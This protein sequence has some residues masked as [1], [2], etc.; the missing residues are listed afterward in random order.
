MEAWGWSG[1]LAV[2]LAAL[3]ARAAGP[4]PDEA[5]EVAI[6]EL[7]DELTQKTPIASGHAEPVQETPGVVTIV[8]REEILSSGARDLLDVLQLVPGFSAVGVDVEG[9]TDFGFR[10]IWAH[11][12]KILLMI[13][14]LPRNEL[15][16]DDNELG[17]HYPVDQIERVEIIRGAGSVLYGGWAEL[18]VIN[19]ITRSAK[20]LSGA[21]GSF[22]YGQMTRGFGQADLNLQAGKADLLGVKGLDLKA[23]LYWG[24][25]NRSD[26]S[27]LDFYGNSYSMLGASSLDPFNIDAALDWKSL[28]V[29]FLY[30]HYQLAEADSYTEVSGCGATG[31]NGSPLPCPYLVGEQFNTTLGDV[32]YDFKLGD[33][34]TLTPRFT[35]KLQ[36]PWY[37][38][39]P[40]AGPQYF[41][42]HAE[43]ATGRLDLSWDLFRDA[44]PWLGSLHL[45]AGTEDYYEDAAL[46]ERPPAGAVANYFGAPQ[47]PGATQCTL[48]DGTP[49][50]CTSMNEYNLAGYAELQWKSL[51]GALTAGARYEHNSEFGDS[52][53]PRGAYTKAFGR[54][55][56]K[57]L[58]SSAFRAPGLEDVNL[59][60][61]GSPIRPE[62]TQDGE[63]ELG[64]QA[65][66]HWYVGANAFY[67]VIKD[68]IVYY[69]TQ[70][71][72]AE[73]YLNFPQTG[74]EG[75][76]A[77]V[78]MKY[79]WGNLK[80]NYSYYTSWSIFTDQSMNQVPLYA[81]P[82]DPSL[83]AGFPA[84]KVSLNGHFVIWKGL[85][86]NPSGNFLSRRYGQWS[87]DGA[88]NG[89][90]SLG[91]ATWLLNL[92][93]LWQDVGV[94]GLDLGAGVY[95]LLNE[96]YAYLQPYQSGH[97]PLPGP[98]REILARLAYALPF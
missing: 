53:V 89:V 17:H 19:V 41:P 32:S 58:Y 68:P 72:A 51:L 27:Y 69:P 84:H 74:T 63:V 79:G 70:N 64:L 86:V 92:Y 49:T 28:H 91:P 42:V 20:D 85:S 5:N 2:A 21:A 40:N 39:D 61:P 98:S 55:H 59:S 43:R 22:V 38:S 75:A 97:A 30:D 71:G 50:N 34:V 80:I 23:A 16:Y 25:G 6:L 15:L 13:D 77:E 18:A 45:L 35:Y 3:P 11:E 8:T 88:G 76:E 78:R 33:R 1:W 57:L 46:D 83:L 87:G 54:F 7:G 12:G 81:V 4:T 24:R 31:L 48:P 60:Q 67:T 62:R 56:V 96:G 65:T 82:N 37:V 26:Q 73:Y 44:G 14:G 66:D 90:G 29:H 36:Q 52:F 94:K 93:V 10:G 47:N 9:V 95:D